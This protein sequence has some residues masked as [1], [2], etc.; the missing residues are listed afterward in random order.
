M[1]LLKWINAHLVVC[2][3]LAM[4]LGVVFGN[5]VDTRS[6][7]SFVSPLSFFMVYPMMV[8]L[9]YKSIFKKGNTKLQLTTQAINFIYLP[10]MAYV[11]GI[12]FFSDEIYMRLGLL[13]IA[14]LPTSGMTVS[15]TVMA[16]GNVTEA[17]RMIV[18]GLILGGLLTPL[19]IK[20]MLQESIA[21]SFIEIINQV[22][23]IVFIPMAL[24]YLT[25]VLVKRLTSEQKFQTRIKPIFPLFSTLALVVLIFIVMSMRA[26]LI[27]SNPSRVLVL[28]VPILLGYFI[29][30]ITIHY[31][32]KKFFSYEDRI[33]LVQGTVIRS[34]SLAL[35]LALTV[36]SSAGP[37]IALIIALAYIVQV[38]VAAQYVKFAVG[39]QLKITPS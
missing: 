27:L 14:L 9:N 6:L 8:T 39:Q 28:L 34:L 2:L 18:I 25:Q 20:L 16:K 30:L 32:G 15:W 35:A 10:I 24:G 7:R 31:L 17:I 11:F 38:Q 19:Y 23:M 29:M 13:L 21:V 12:L 22:V 4:I 37:E 1:K 5:Y 36:F 3:L 26:Q 33:A